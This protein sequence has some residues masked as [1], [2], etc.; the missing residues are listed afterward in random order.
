MQDIYV[1]IQV[2]YT[3]KDCPA[4]ILIDEEFINS[5]RK[6]KVKTTARDEAKESVL[7]AY[8]GYD[9]C[10]ID[11]TAGRYL[12]M[13]NVTGEYLKYEEYFVAFTSK[14]EARR[15]AS[16]VNAEIVY[17][18]ISNSNAKYIDADGLAV[19]IIDGKVR[20]VDVNN[21]LKATKDS[22]TGMANTESVTLAVEGDKFIITPNE[23][24][25]HPVIRIPLDRITFG[26]VK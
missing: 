17:T 15:S 23:G 5:T 26:P 13:S 14:E 18:I 16:T 19:A 20:L 10:G 22:I 9:V 6:K 12:L 11:E 7:K 8:T 24:S 1:P 2:N 4:Y 25:E 21:K 3:F